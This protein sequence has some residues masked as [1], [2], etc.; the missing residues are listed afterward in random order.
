MVHRWQLR[1]MPD[2]FEIFGAADQSDRARTYVPVACA[3]KS[4]SEILNSHRDFILGAAKED[5]LL[6]DWF[7]H[8]K[9]RSDVSIPPALFQRSGHRIRRLISAD[10]PEYSWEEYRAT[11][12][13]LSWVPSLNPMNQLGQAALHRRRRSI[14]PTLRRSHGYSCCTSVAV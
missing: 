12:S 4:T 9:R 11:L 8:R 3:N 2:Q 1:A 5:C 6:G 14:G 13:A 7:R 10:T